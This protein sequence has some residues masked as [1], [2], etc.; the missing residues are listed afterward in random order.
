[1]KAHIIEEPKVPPTTLGQFKKVYDKIKDNPDDMPVTFEFIMSA[2]FPQVYNNMKEHLRLVYDQ[3]V[4]D[5]IEVAREG[6]AI[7]NDSDTNS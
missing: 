1:M 5:G 6:D 2:F 4:K 7:K 3:G